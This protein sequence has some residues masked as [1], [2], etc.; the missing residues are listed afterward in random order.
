MFKKITKFFL[1]VKQEFGKVSWPTRNELKGTTII[2]IILTAILTLYIFG[3]DKL[4]QM[5]LNLI[6]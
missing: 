2:V 5:I 1:E 6:F 3:I 4:L